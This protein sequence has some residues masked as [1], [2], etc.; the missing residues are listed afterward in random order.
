MGKKPR[1]AILTNSP[2]SGVLAPRA[3]AFAHGLTPEF[4]VEVFWR[5]SARATAILA[6]LAKLQAFRPDLL[7][8][9]DQGYPVV[10]ASLF[11]RAIVSCP[12]VIETGD[13]LAE[14]LWAAGRVGSVGRAA[15]RKYERAVLR[16]ADHVV[17]RGSGLREY[18][19][20]FGVTRVTVVPD[21][22]DTRVF[23]PMDVGDLRKALGLEGSV[24]IGVMGTL[25]WSERLQWGYGCELIEA[26]TLLKGLSVYGM[27]LGDGPGRKILERKAAE[28][29]VG[30]RVKFVGYVPQDLLPPYINAMDICLSTQT[31][32]WVGRARTTAKLPLFLACG[33]FVFASRVGEAAQVL[34][35]EMLVD[36]A[37][38]F[39]PAYPERLA[40]RIEHV[41]RN[42]EL[43]R[44]GEHCRRI[45]EAEF[46]YARLVPR[47]AE[48]VKSVLDGRGCVR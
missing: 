23:H 38:G 17:V 29:G 8:V 16:R 18:V 28:R 21:G 10:L 5:Y 19:A 13:P 1:V 4:R 41:V 20:R 42:P 30:E 46:D 26:L 2:P 34:P 7:Y 9:I 36:Y 15:I 32:D 24:S 39:D 11:Y 45:A 27:V 48:V 25:N 44:L 12:L 35:A 33:R 47:V 6:F 3:L 14:L 43:L 37:E 22:V 40:H 31:N